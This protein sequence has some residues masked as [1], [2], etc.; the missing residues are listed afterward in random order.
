[1]SGAP[2]RIVV[3]VTAITIHNVLTTILAE[4]NL[5]KASSILFA[6]LNYDAANAYTVTIESGELAGALDAGFVATFDVPPTAGGKTG[7][8]SYV[9]GPDQL[10][11]LY[12]VSAVSIG[13]GDVLG[14]WK[15]AVVERGFPWHR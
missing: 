15:L 8:N 13:G 1:M 12:R 14:A 10:R 4:T 3:P 5:A 7:Q 2:L 9:V 11:S 6:F